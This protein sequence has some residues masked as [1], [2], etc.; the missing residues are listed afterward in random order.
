MEREWKSSRTFRKCTDYRSQKEKC[1]KLPG[2]G[3]TLVDS[4][5]GGS[6]MMA[7]ATKNGRPT[8]R[9]VAE[10]AGVSRMTVS[11]VLRGRNDAMSPETRERVLEAVRTMNYVPVQPV[12]QNRHV[13]TRVIALVLG[14]PEGIK[15]TI[16]S[17]TYEG[18]CSAALRH[19]YDLLTLLRPEPEWAFGRDDTLF[20]DRRSDG[21]IFATP[22]HRGKAESFQMLLDNDIPTVVCYRRDVP[23]GIIW[24]DPDNEA[25]A[26]AAITH[27]AELGHRH[28]AHLTDKQDL[29]DKWQRLHCFERE[30][31]RLGL[32]GSVVET[33]YSFSTRKPPMEALE[34]IRRTGATAVWAFNDPL[35]LDLWDAAQQTGCR[36]PEELSLV[37]VDNTP[38]ARQRGLTSL[39]FT[40]V[41]VGMQ[42]VEALVA[43]LR[44]EEAAD[45]CRVVP[46]QLFVRSSTAPPAK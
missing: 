32:R 12:L 5:P 43:R 10:R 38:E 33:E 29:F 1:L 9:Q 27:L 44:G 2:S 24:I 4:Q 39:G 18:M 14:R 8:I 30:I 31:A 42:A 3:Y 45:L 26:R 41:E 22:G 35:A 15:W 34:T 20:L 37:G 7:K 16:H 46:V 6:I 13:E 23:D 28:I 17:Q 19:G 25:I 40:F 21:V 36:V 11:N